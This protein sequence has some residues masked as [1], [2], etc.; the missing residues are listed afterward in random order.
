MSR[1]DD[2][3]DLPHYEPRHPRM[4][5]ENRAAQFAPFAAL[6]GHGAAIVETARLTESMTELSPEE[7]LR[8]SRRLI[9]AYEK[10]VHVTVTYFIPDRIKAGGKYGKTYGKIKKIDDIERVII[11]EEGQMIPLNFIASIESD[12]IDNLEY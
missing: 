9:T 12:E 6:T 11:F 3:I 10:H 8:L 2:I 1:Y 7:Q 5:L 4:T